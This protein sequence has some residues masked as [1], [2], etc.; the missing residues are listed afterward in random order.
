MCIRER[1]MLASLHGAVMAK[2]MRERQHQRIAPVQDVDLLALLFGETEARDHADVYKRQRF[3]RPVRKYWGG[4]RY[5]DL[6]GYVALA[7]D[8]GRE[9]LQLSLIHI[10]LIERICAFSLSVSPNKD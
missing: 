9:V 7:Y 1:D 5:F 2:I 6:Y 3:S 4:I 8:A 10:W